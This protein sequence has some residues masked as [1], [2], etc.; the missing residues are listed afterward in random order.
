MKIKFRAFITYAKVSIN[1]E[2]DEL[3]DIK[4]DWVYKKIAQKWL[5]IRKISS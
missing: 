3:I 2:G 4:Q 1:E 5:H